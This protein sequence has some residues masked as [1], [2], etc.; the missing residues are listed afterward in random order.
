MELLEISYQLEFSDA[1]R[2]KVADRLRPENFTSD[3]T[4]MAV[5]DGL[6]MARKSL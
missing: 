5:E 2:A 4:R 1:D 6:Q 3:A